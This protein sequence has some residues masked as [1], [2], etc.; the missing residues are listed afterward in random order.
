MKMM[1]R[2]IKK[3]I[4]KKINIKDSMKKSHR[5]KMNILNMI[6]IIIMISI[7]MRNLFRISFK[8]GNPQTF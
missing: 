8:L 3:E 2:S 6:R 4:F 5:A 7:R 1:I